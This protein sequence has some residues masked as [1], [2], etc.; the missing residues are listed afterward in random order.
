MNNPDSRILRFIRKHHVLTLATCVNNKPW[1]SNM[2]YVY[3][4]DENVFLFTSE[5]STKH[6]AD[7]RNN[8]L[9]AASVVLETKIIGRIQ[10]LQMQGRITKPE[11]EIEARLRSLYR[12]RFPYSAMM[13]LSLWVLE[14]DH[15]KMTNNAFGFGTKVYWDRQ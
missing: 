4:P 12:K 7:F 8:S 10:G 13:D 3:I 9:V 14:P 6:V 5:D 15:M 11:G 2:F 1:C